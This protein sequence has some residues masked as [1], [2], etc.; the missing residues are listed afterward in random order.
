MKLQYTSF[1]ML[2]MC[3][4]TNTYAIDVEKIPGTLPHHQTRP[5][6]LFLAKLTTGDKSPK[7]EKK[8]LSPTTQTEFEFKVSGSLKKEMTAILSQSQ[9]TSFDVSGHKITD[10]ELLVITGKHLGL[11]RIVLL[12]SSDITNKGLKNFSSLKNLESIDFSGTRVNSD[13]LEFLLALDNLKEIKL[14]NIILSKDFLVNLLEKKGLKVSYDPQN[15]I[16]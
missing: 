14:H 11:R 12:N 7:S 15:I 1:W 16:S 9:L 10:A 8:N 3:S 4:L 6:S 13:G 5:P 2:F